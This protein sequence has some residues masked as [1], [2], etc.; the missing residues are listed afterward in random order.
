MT[1]AAESAR[2]VTWTLVVA[3]ALLV[4]L[5]LADAGTTLAGLQVG[6]REL[7][8]LLSRAMHA[9]G[10]GGLLGIKAVVCAG[11]LPYLLVR[12]RLAILR[13]ANAVSFAIVTANVLQLAAFGH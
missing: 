7:N 11:L 3:S 1:G 6:A 10:V 12:R 9:W 13:A 4:V 2:A 5:Q 8:P